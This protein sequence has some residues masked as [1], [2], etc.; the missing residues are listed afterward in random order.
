LNSAHLTEAAGGRGGAGI[1][2]TPPRPIR[3]RPSHI[4]RSDAAG[5]GDACLVVLHPR[6]SPVANDEGEVNIAGRRRP[7]IAMQ[8]IPVTTSGWA[9]E[10][11]GNEPSATNRFITTNL[12]ISAAAHG[13][14]PRWEP[15]RISRSSAILNTRNISI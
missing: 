5:A 2:V 11:G 7:N 10:G 12:N 1:H 4:H 14:E 6:P 13:A 15:I 3:L 9:E 8:V